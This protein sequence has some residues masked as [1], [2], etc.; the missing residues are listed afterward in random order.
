MPHPENLAQPQTLSA[1]PDAELTSVLQTSAVGG[2]SMILAP[3][4][5]I[6]SPVSVM[7]STVLDSPPLPA[8]RTPTNAPLACSAK[9]MLEM[10]TAPA[11]LCSPLESALPVNVLLDTSARNNHLLTNINASPFKHAILVITVEILI[12]CARAQG[13]A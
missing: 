6:A 9:R 7:E 5:W 8:A 1:H 4:T 3:P 10:R 2:M 11:L 13:G 12:A